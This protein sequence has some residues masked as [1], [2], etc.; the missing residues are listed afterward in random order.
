MSTAAGVGTRTT[1]FSIPCSVSRLGLLGAG[2]VAGASVLTDAMIVAVVVVVVVVVVMSGASAGRR[3][4]RDNV[5]LLQGMV[6][7]TGTK[8]VDCTQESRVHCPVALPQ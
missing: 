2:A 7:S 5:W 4:R 6:H 3:G 1:M 8:P